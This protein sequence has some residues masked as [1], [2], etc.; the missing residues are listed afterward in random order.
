MSFEPLDARVEY[1]VW[2]DNG[3]GDAGIAEFESIEEAD[4]FSTSNNIHQRER[5]IW[6]ME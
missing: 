6:N 3:D 5:F 1:R 4:Q 2:Y